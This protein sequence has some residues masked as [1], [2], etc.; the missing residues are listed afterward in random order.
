MMA[1]LLAAALTTQQPTQEIDILDA[2]AVSR[3][4]ASLRAADPAVC[5]MAGRTLTNQW[6]WGHD[7]ADE[8][9]PVPMPTPMP[10]PMPMPF[11]GS[12]P[13]ISGPNVGDRAGRALDAKVLAVFRAALRDQS[14]CIRRIAARVVAR[15]EP[16]WAP[17]EFGALAKEADAGLREIAL[18]GLG[19]LEDPRTLGTMT[20]A[21]GDRDVNVRAMAAWALGQLEDTRG[22]GP[23]GKAL[24]DESPLVRRRSA[25]ALGEIENDAALTE[26]ERA[27]RDRDATVRRTAAWAMGEIE[28]ATAV[29]LLRTALADS[30]TSVRPT[31]IWAV[32][33]IE[34]AS[35]VEVLAPLVK[36][37]DARVRRMAVWA[38]GELESDRGVSVLAPAMRDSDRDVKLTALWALGQIEDE[39]GVDV[40]A[41]ALKDRDAGVRQMA[42][43]ALGQIE[44][45]TAVGSLT[46]LL[47]DSDTD[48]RVVAAWA[49][50]QIESGSALPAL[51]AVKDDQ[52]LG[53]TTR[54]AMG[55]STDRR[56]PRLDGR[57]RHSIVERDSAIGVSR[58]VDGLGLEG[59]GRLWFFRPFLE[60][61]TRHVIARARSQCGPGFS[62]VAVKPANDQA[63]PCTDALGC[64]LLRRRPATPPLSTFLRRQ[65][66][67]QKGIALGGADRTD[68]ADVQFVAIETETGGSQLHKSGRRR[69]TRPTLSPYRPAGPA[70]QRRIL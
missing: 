40:V 63:Q 5:E 24:G 46:P 66:R 32:G 49:L 50:G 7:I 19:Q 8:P 9:M 48:V 65:P 47:N 23:L 21:L 64:R 38:I 25:W 11:A 35:G 67:G 12:G 14:R 58:R 60:V 31:A 42:A 13:D 34:D 52:S 22:I 69:G 3:Q 57:R 2:D 45:A 1:T 30:D 70:D 51:E 54:R 53:S 44:S 4:L 20:T 16:A 28:S 41:P 59:P 56:Q 6:G 10:V 15:E 26:L 61:Q 17:S 55:N 39:A 33:E 18:L 62:R 36:D 43:W 29:P 27:L 68:V 37:A